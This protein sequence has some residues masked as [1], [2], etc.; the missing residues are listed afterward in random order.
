MSYL[1][2]QAGNAAPNIRF[3]IPLLFLIETSVYKQQHVH[4]NKWSCK[5]ASSGVGLR[6]YRSMTGQTAFFNAKQ[7]AEAFILRRDQR[8]GQFGSKLTR[9]RKHVI[10]GQFVQKQN[11]WLSI[12][13]HMFL[14]Y[15]TKCY[16]A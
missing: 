5:T 4:D 7:P 2:I 11:V 10:E 14:A 12:K 8:K 16:I 6:L 9:A 1:K 15:G 13:R 3:D